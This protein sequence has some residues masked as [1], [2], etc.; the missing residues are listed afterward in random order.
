MKAHI[1]CLFLGIIMSCGIASFAIASGAAPGSAS[2]TYQNRA[3]NVVVQAVLP[4]LAQR[5][6]QLMAAGRT[7]IYYRV[8][9]DGHVESVRVVSARANAFVQDTC[10]RV[11]KSKKFPPIPEA[12]QREQKKSYLDMSSQIGG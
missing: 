4:A 7:K 1:L 10:S 2:L 5:I 11:L 8:R 6:D 12:V 9:A 3:S